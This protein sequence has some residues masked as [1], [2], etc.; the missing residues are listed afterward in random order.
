[1]DLFATAPSGSFVKS[2]KGSFMVQ[3]DEIIGMQI[4]AFGVG[5]GSEPPPWNPLRSENDDV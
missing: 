5:S 1:M 3:R 2:P 4:H